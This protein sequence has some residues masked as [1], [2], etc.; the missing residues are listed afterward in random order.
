M[1]NMQHIQISR[2]SHLDKALQI[3]D[4]H[5]VQR[6]HLKVLF[7][8]ELE[9]LGLKAL[10]QEVIDE[11]GSEHQVLHYQNGQD[12]KR[13]GCLLHVACRYVALS[14]A[15]RRTVLKAFNPLMVFAN[16]SFVGKRSNSSL[17]VRYV[18][19]LGIVLPFKF[20]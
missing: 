20:R 8:R 4:L 9:A 17:Y 19:G 2:L 14:L 1:K 7:R 18:P 15:V 6:Q 12:I 16:S 3:G 10:V 5:N 11:W 13:V